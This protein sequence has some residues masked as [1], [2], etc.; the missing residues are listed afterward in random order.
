MPTIIYIP[1]VAIEGA[2]QLKFT[3]IYIIAIRDV[4]TNNIGRAHFR[5]KNRPDDVYLNLSKYG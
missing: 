2:P 4:I 5:D 3:C 1:F